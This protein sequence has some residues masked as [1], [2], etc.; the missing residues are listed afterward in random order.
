MVGIKLIDYY[1]GN[2]VISSIL[3]ITLMLAGLQIFV[4]FV[5]ELGDLG[6][7]SYGVTQALMYILSQLPH[8]IYLFFP[9]ACLLGSLMGLGVLAANSELIVIRTAGVSVGQVVVSVLKSSLILIIAV[10]ALTEWF[11]PGLLNN[12]EVRKVVAKSGG[13]AIKTATGSWM[14]D[15]N[16]FIYVGQ[17]QTDGLLLNVM[18]FTFNEQQQLVL[19]RYAEKAV[20]TDEQWTLYQ[21]RQSVIHPDQ[22]QAQTLDQLTWEVRLNSQVLQVGLTEPEAMSIGQLW[23]YVNEQKRNRLQVNDAE[24][25]LYKRLFQPL[26]SCVMLLLAIPFIFGPLRSSTVGARFLTG[27]MMGFGFYMLDKFFGPVSLVYQVPPLLAALTP[28]LLFSVIGVWM[29]RRVR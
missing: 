14:R 7:G 29:M 19:S 4:L 3:L 12:A 25:V 23:H 9:V 1:I 16:N 11:S 5:L 6:Q 20:L 15:Q 10:T 26:A 27:C 18:Q 2:T 21:V 17:V 8:Q 22:I 24:F 28:T 13:Q